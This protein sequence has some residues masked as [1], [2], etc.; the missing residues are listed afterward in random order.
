M[1]QSVPQPQHFSREELEVRS[2][3]WWREVVR[4]EALP[5]QADQVG[6]LGVKSPQLGP[7]HQ[8]LLLCPG[9]SRGARDVLG[10]GMVY[11]DQA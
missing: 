3:V 2:D 6:V 11:R 5:P 7:H 8:Q 4:D 9:G 1:R 10:G